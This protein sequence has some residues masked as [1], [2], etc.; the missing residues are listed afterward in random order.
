MNNQEQKSLHRI[1][2]NAMTLLLEKGIYAVCSFIYIPYTVHA[3]G[4]SSFGYMLLVITY[5]GIIGDITNLVSWKTVL[6]YGTAPFHNGNRHQFYQVLRFAAQ[7]DLLSAIA[8][9]AVGILGIMLFS[10]YFDWPDEIIPVAEIC[11]L[12][13][14][15][16]RT[17]WC[18]GATRL[19]DKFKYLTVGNGI[20]AVVR[21]L[22]CMIGD[23]CHFGLDYFMYLWLASAGMVFLGDVTAAVYAL[24]QHS[25][26]RPS[27][28]EMFHTPEIL[29]G[30]WHF[31]LMTSIN[32]VLLS[33]ARKLPTLLIGSHIGPSEAA[34]FKV[35][36]QITDGIVRPARAL[37]PS[38]YPEF[39]HLR[40]KGR[41]DEIRAVIRKILIYATI[42]SSLVI[43][44]SV[45]F[46]GFLLHALIGT[47][48]DG[49][50]ILSILVCGSLMSIL[51]MPLEPFMVITG[52]LGS[53]LRFRLLSIVISLP[54][55]VSF[56]YLFGGIGAALTFVMTSAAT[57]LFFAIQTRK[58][59][60][61]TKALDQGIRH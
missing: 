29:N 50:H 58:A 19:L 20:T 46:G 18:V 55:L 59:F 43:F 26:K 48:G 44:I 45:E 33:V 34:I 60:M 1:I 61:I 11:M 17:G 15:L 39:V 52:K 42:F 27:W 28:R 31:T 25:M 3:I 37:T 2:K 14:V 22:G 53:V 47:D 30:A 24:R 35:S 23:Y 4:L 21:T 57:L 49:S 16:D 40:E 36:T 7:L 5:I 12:A 6:H 10:S 38:L 13:V 9:Y 51:S 56:V 41:L 32:Q 8:G 54:I